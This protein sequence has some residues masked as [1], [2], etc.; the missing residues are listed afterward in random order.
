MKIRPYKYQKQGVRMLEAFDGRALLAD[1][2]GLGKT[3]QALLYAERNI[4]GPILIVCPNNLKIN[5]AREVAKVLG[6]EACI[7]EGRNAPK[8]MR[9]P[10]VL[11][12]NYEI[13]EN[14]VAVIKRNDPSLIVFDECHY[15]KNIEAKRTIAAHNIGKRAK[16]VIGLSGTPLTNRPAELWSILKIIQP[17]RFRSQ[18]AFCWKY[19]LPK[20]TPWGWQYNGANNLSKLHKI[21]KRTCMI[22]RRK[23]DVLKELP[24]KTRIIIPIHLEDRREYD[25]AERDIIGWLGKTS[26]T[27]ARKAARAKAITRYTL[28]K[29]LATNLKMPYVTT[30]VNDFLEESDAKMLVFGHHADVLETLHKSYK[31]ISVLVRGTTPKAKRQMFV[32]KF[33]DHAKTRLFFGNDKAAGEGLTLTAAE[34]VS[35]VEIPWTPAMCSQIEDRAHRIGQVKNVTCYYLVAQDTIEEDLCSMIQEKQETLDQTLDGLDTSNS[36]N[37][38]DRLAAAILER[39]RR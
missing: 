29:R 10:D 4:S 38:M 18:L 16:H 30:W 17:K 1:E 7:A 2:M 21:L 9:I 28:L 27:K 39:T 19:T 8:R 6:V 12:I 25:E 36:L 23:V 11:I 20:K 35:Q 37:L 13:L 5:W 24:S 14:W 3:I 26:K 31:D 22:R 15:L 33:Q 32:D 34:A